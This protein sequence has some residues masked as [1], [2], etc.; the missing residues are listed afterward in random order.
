[1]RTA[2]LEQRLPGAVED[3]VLVLHAREMALLQL[4]CGFRL[5]S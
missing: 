3:A 2:E 1:V 4:L 5:A